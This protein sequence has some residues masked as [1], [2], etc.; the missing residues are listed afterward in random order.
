ML[1]KPTPF[2]V[3][4]VCLNMREGDKQEIFSLRPHDSWYALSYECYHT[5]LNNGRGVVSWVGGEPVGLGAFT[6]HHP[7]VWEVWMF[8]TD[9]FVSGLKP[10]MRWIRD[11]ANDILTTQKAHRLH[12]DSRSGYEEAHKLIRAMGGVQESV[13]RGYGKDGSDYIRFVWIRG[14]NDAFLRPHYVKEKAHASFETE[15]A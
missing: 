9:Q 14:E 7:G 3:D 12:C 6:E 11:E 10:L 5:I 2:S 4:Q 8:G 1:L 13:M 15:N